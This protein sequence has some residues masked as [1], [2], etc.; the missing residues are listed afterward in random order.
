MTAE[1]KAERDAG[2]IVMSEVTTQPGRRLGP[3]WVRTQ[4]VLLQYK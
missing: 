4:T 1:E 2:R 3:I